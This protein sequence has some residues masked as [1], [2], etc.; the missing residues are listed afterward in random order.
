MAGEALPPVAAALAELQRLQVAA[1]PLA[2]WCRLVLRG[3]TAPEGALAA[4][5][6][7]TIRL[8]EGLAG[9]CSPREIPSRYRDTTPSLEERIRALEASQRTEELEA[10]ACQLD[11]SSD[12]W[13][14]VIKEVFRGLLPRPGAP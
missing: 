5:A 8:V 11:E 14:G 13:L 3:G 1:R 9:R 4:R 6:E 7:E 2:E 12:R 10:L